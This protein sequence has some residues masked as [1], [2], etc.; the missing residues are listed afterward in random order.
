MKS[1]AETVARDSEST[2]VRESRA[3]N[4]ESAIGNLEAIGGEVV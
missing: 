1:I 2:S 3:G 4:G